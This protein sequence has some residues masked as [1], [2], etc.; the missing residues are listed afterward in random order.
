MVELVKELNRLG[1]HKQNAN[2]YI[3]AWQMV[4][5]VITATEVN[6][7]FWLRI[8]EAAQPEIRELATCMFQAL[9]QSTP[10][11]LKPNEW[12]LPYFEDGYWKTD[13]PISLEDARLVSVSCCAQ[14]SYRT[15]DVS[16]EKAHSLFNRL[17]GG[18]PKHAS[19]TEHQ[20]TPMEVTTHADERTLL[21]NE[22]A[23]GYTHLDCHWQYWSGNFKHWIQYRQLIENQN[24]TQDFRYACSH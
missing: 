1:L 3:E 13:N 5:I 19:P 15:H 6:N 24:L 17:I 8:H 22:A 11:R 14:T 18:I 12:H 16:I 4:K 2:R 9:Q 23:E 20:A 21:F 7:Y 10:T